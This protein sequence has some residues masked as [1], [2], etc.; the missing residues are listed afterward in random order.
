MKTYSIKEVPFFFI[1]L[2]GSISLLIASREFIVTNEVLEDHLIQQHSVDQIQKLLDS[3][4]KFAWIRYALL[5]LFYLVKLT[6]ISLWIICGFILFGYNNS[7]KKVFRVVLIAEF[8]WLIPPFITLTWFGLVDINYTLIDVQYFK[9]LSL[10]NFF[11]ASEVE[12]WLIFP[13]QSLNLFELV[14]VLVLAIG[15]KKMLKKDYNTAL[16][17]TIPVYGSA[18]FVWVVFYSLISVNLF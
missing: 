4:D 12:N 10:L 13:L 18:V 5:P 3:Q 7:F 17:F 6:L 8:V 14:Y 15:I 1:L 11:E 9:P 16:N 2:A